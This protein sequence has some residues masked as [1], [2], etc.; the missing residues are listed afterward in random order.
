MKK[1]LIHQEILVSTGSTLAKKLL[2]E[3]MNNN[4][5]SSAEKFD[6]EFWGYFLKEI[7]FE[8][9]PPD[10]NYSDVSILGIYKGKSYFLIELAD[11]PGPIESFL[12]INPHLYLCEMN[13]N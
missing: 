13:M 11:I 5:A 2:F 9:L 12:S 3:T 7:F 8:Q 6:E 4:K 10:S 1:Q